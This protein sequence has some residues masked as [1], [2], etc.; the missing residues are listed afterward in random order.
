MS[1]DHIAILGTGSWG[2]TLAVLCARQGANV[3][4]WA[5]TADESAALNA[6]REN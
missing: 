1:S 5:R 3:S 4:L 2:T 6:R